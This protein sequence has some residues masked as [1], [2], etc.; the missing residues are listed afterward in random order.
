M[1]GVAAG[2]HLLLSL[3]DDCDESAVVDRGE[4]WNPGVRCGCIPGAS[5]ACAPALLV[6]YG[7]IEQARIDEAVAELARVIGDVHRAR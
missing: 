1:Q 6:G 5:A 7:G 4:E 2:L 3:P